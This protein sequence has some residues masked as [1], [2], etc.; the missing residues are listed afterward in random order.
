MMLYCIGDTFY[1]EEEYIKYKVERIKKFVRAKERLRELRSHS[2]IVGKTTRKIVGEYTQTFS[3]CRGGIGGQVWTQDGNG[4]V[5]ALTFS[6]IKKL[7]T[8]ERIVE[9]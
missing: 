3:V 8:E 5:R 6:E 4:S 9:L 2:S 1:S 7:L